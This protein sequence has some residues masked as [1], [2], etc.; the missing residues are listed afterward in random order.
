MRGLFSNTTKSRSS[1]SHGAVRVTQRRITLGQAPHTILSE[2]FPFRFHKDESFRYGTAD[3]TPSLRLCFRSFS[4]TCYSLGIPSSTSPPHSFNAAPDDKELAGGLKRSSEDRKGS[5]SH[6]NGNNTTPTSASSSTSS[7]SSPIYQIP[8]LASRLVG[9]QQELLFLWQQLLRGKHT[10]IVT[11][12][13]GIGKSS[14]CAEF[15]DRATR[16]ERFSCVRWLNAG[17]GQITDLKEELRKLFSS[18]MGRRELDVLLVLDDVPSEKM[19]ETLSILPA[20]PQL[21]ILLSTNG[22]VHRRGEEIEESSSNMGDK[23]G[24]EQKETVPLPSTSGEAA[25]SGSFA[26]TIAPKQEIGKEHSKE[27]HQKSEV[28]KNMKERKVVGPVVFSL[29]PLAPE[30]VNHFHAR[31]SPLK[32]GRD[33]DLLREVYEYCARVPLLLEVA[34]PL[35]E[36]KCFESPQLFRAYLKEHHGLASSDNHTCSSSSSEEVKRMGN[37]SITR[38]VSVSKILSSLVNRSLQAMEKEC[39]TVR[40]QFA[41]LACLHTEDISESV[42]SLVF[43]AGGGSSDS[44]MANIRTQ[45]I[46]PTTSPSAANNALGVALGV[47]FGLLRQQW[48]VSG[49]YRMHSTTAAVLRQ[50]YAEKSGKDFHELISFAA[51]CVGRIWPKRW[52]GLKFVEAMSL[53]RHAN[54]LL[55]HYEKFSAS[56]PSPSTSSSFSPNPD[57]VR[58]PCPPLMFILDKS[59]QFLAYYARQDLP[60]AGN[61]WHAVFRQYLLL[62]SS[63]SALSTVSSF[64]LATPY[65]NLVDIREAVRVGTDCGRLLHYLN[66]ER[67][68]HVLE[69]TR[70][71]CFNAHGEVSKEYGILLSYLAPYLSATSSNLDLLEKGICALEYALSSDAS[72]STEEILSLEEAKMLREALFVVLLRKGQAVQESGDVV[73]NSLWERLLE[74]ERE[75]KALSKKN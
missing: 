65:S 58:I 32:E 37:S 10:L 70:Q 44:G 7:S 40:K 15:C 16:S 26:T 12:V 41:L 11:G 4:A 2:H 59:A 33:E 61:M 8:V 38:E 36:Q 14:L 28:K 60:L 67:A 13:N 18:M 48:S 50:H 24:K 72:S 57:A 25:S 6:F 35:V 54:V 56:L 30:E 21:Y 43:T 49:G 3:G 46:P 68:Y 69:T 52:R 63:D 19:E 22:D 66:D 27:A 64:P 53:V 39:P 73:P 47:T 31:L 55:S 45:G 17:S 62:F 1:V 51:D 20:H 74:I 34:V 29:G 23:K 5:S 42:A 9:R 71:W 75:I